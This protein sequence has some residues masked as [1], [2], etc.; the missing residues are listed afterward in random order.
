MFLGVSLFLY[1]P[2][3]KSITLSSW[4]YTRIAQKAAKDTEIESGFSVA[5]SGT[6][7]FFYCF[8]A[9]LQTPPAS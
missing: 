7:I 1:L 2:G 3:F 5:N 6:F 4:S 9:L 8:P